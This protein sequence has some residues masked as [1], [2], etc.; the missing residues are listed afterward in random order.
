MSTIRVQGVNKVFGDNPR[1]A[2]PLIEQGLTRDEIQERTG[3]VVGVRDATFEVTDGEFFV[4]MGL[5]GSGKSTLVRMFNRLI[6]PTS[7]TIEIDGVDITRLSDRELRGLR[8]T[9]VSMVFQRFALFPHQTV[10]DNTAFGLEVQGL[11]RKERHRRAN[12]ALEMVGLGNWGDRYPSELSGGMQ[13]RV[14]LAR[15]LATD[16]DIL[17][18]DEAF[19]A[20]DPLIRREMQDHLLQLQEELQKTVVFITHDLNEAMRLGDRIAVMKDGAIVQIGTSE[21]ILTKPAT[22]YVAAFT[23][24]VDPNRVL[25]ASSIMRD[26]AGTVSPEVGPRV[27]MARLKELQRNEVYAVRPDRTLTGYVRD[28][29]LSEAARRG[30]QTLTSAL[31]TD[32]PVATPDTY[33]SD[34]YALSVEHSLPIAV[35]DERGRLVGVVPRVSLL[36]ALAA[37]SA[38]AE[39]VNGTNGT[40]GASD[41]NAGDEGAGD[42]EGGGGDA[43]GSAAGPTAGLAAVKGAASA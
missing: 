12:E 23:Q 39:N 38:R 18:M 33:I 21:E 10:L 42:S 17:L 19:S 20:L 11:D 28:T 15:A 8:S 36:T 22:D 3:L 35:V 14:G 37:I 40:N 4:V 26:A 30:E 25:T 24:D 2:L 43:G 1:R 29:D 31:R 9:K 7:G 32:Y 34:L 41:E 6:E 13:Q 16:A 27:A 5:S